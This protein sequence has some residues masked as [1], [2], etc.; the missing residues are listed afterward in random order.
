M[1]ETHTPGPWKAD[2]HAYMVFAENPYKR[3]DMHVADIRGWGHLTGKGGGCAMPDDKAEAI[4]RANANLIAAAP[5]LLA[6]LRYIAN[7][8]P[9]EWHE[10]TRSDFQAWA[11]NRA[12]AA[13]AKAEGR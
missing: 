2:K 4:Q 3:D 1:S 5:D 6:E 13:I 7:A 11:Q 10:E 9:H 12:R 8:N